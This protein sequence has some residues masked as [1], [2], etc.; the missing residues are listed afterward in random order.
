MNDR[1]ILEIYNAGRHEGY[2]VV[3][4]GLASDDGSSQKPSDDG[5][6]EE[7]Y[8]EDEFKEVVRGVHLLN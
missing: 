8:V 4:L 6:Q 3:P 1:D 7:L 2:D 5:Q